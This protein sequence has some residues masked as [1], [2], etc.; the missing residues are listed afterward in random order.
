MKFQSRYSLPMQNLSKQQNP[1][2]IQWIEHWSKHNVTLS[3][4]ATVTGQ[5]LDW[6]NITLLPADDHNLPVLTLIHL[7]Q[8]SGV[9]HKFTLSYSNQ[10]LLSSHQI[11]E[12]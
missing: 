3:E 7:F 11:C 6:E 12:I 10:T 4:T 2:I 5:Q 1:I 9:N 8:I